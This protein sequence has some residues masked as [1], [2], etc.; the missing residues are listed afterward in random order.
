MSD[1][2]TEPEQELEADGWALTRQLALIFLGMSVF[3]LFF[4]ALFVLDR[5]PAGYYDHPL[6]LSIG[7][8]LLLHDVAAVLLIVWSWVRP[9]R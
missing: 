3:F 4:I 6:L 7:A 2:Q 5:G 1:D 9:R 8:V